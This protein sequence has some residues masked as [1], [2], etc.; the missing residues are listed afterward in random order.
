MIYIVKSLFNKDITDGLYEGCLSAMKEKGIEAEIHL[1]D[2]PGA[3]DIPGAVSKIVKKD[4][5]ELIITLGCVIKGDTDHYHYICDAV[6]NGI[7]KLTIQSETPILFG[8]LTCQNK[9]FALI[10]SGENMKKNK[11]YE[12]GIMAYKLLLKEP[13]SKVR[14]GKK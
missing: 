5:A 7:M 3:F 1:K 6:S 13:T 10:R 2:V 4:S 14:Y 11:G 9:E 12:L 8:I